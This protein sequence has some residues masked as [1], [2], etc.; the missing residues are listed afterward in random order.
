MEEMAELLAGGL[1]SLSVVDPAS[2]DS[3]VNTLVDWTLES[4]NLQSA[5]CQPETPYKVRH[6]KMGIRFTGQ[7]LLLY[8]QLTLRLLVSYYCTV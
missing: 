3:T 2:F 7:M 1:A 4:L 5:M 8:D 6:L